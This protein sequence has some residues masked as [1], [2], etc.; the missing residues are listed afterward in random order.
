MKQ[1]IY[2]TNSQT[3]LVKNSHSISSFNKIPTSEALLKV[4]LPESKIKLRLFNNPIGCYL[5]YC[6]GQI[7]TNREI[8]VNT[9]DRESR[10]VRNRILL[11]WLT[12]TIPLILYLK[13]VYWDQNI[14]I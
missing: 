1:N 7:V 13:F 9:A 12:L 14:E 5:E 2:R 3:T 10:A 8:C 11:C 6:A 4:P